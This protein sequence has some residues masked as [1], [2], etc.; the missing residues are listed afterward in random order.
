MNGEGAHALAAIARLEAGGA[1][2]R[3]VHEGRTVCWRVFGHGRPLVLV[4][5]GHGNWMHWIRNIAALA[6]R[7]AVCV[8]DL[9]G[10]GDSDDVD[11]DPHAPARLQRLVEATIGSLDTLLGRRAEVDLAGFS[12]G[13]LVAAHIA[14]Q[15]PVRRLALLGPAGHGTRRRPRE[16]L[17]DWRL[18]DPAKRLAALRHNLMAHMLHDPACAD[19]LAMAVHEAACART[20]FRS[21]ALSHAAALQAVL[22]RFARPLLF[23]WG[24]HD[25]TGVPEELAPRLA[26]GHDEREWCLVPGAGHWVQYERDRDINRLLLHWF[27]AGSDAS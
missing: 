8:P 9:P 21:K 3:V 10:F 19:A 7:H 17:V 18:P 15:R 22:Q 27:G 2:H 1:R 26:E 24:E 5:G 20:R 4:H 25:V 13:A 12:F 16:A 6:E 11:A 23:V 14:V